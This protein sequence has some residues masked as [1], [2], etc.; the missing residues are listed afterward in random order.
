MIDE[1]LR[2]VSSVGVTDIIGRYPGPRR[3]QL[4]IL[5]QRVDR[6]GMRLS[7]LEAYVPH[8]DIMRSR[9][10]RDEQ[11]ESYLRLIGHMGKLGVEVCCYKFMPLEERARTG[12]EPVERGGTEV[13]AFEVDQYPPDE[14]GPRVTSAQPW[15]NLKCFLQRVVPAAEAVNIKLAMHPDDAPIASF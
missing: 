4:V 12:L 7:V 3:D 1:N 10:R 11:I 2:L 14:H 9:P 8:G 15:D 13:T 5:C 6:H